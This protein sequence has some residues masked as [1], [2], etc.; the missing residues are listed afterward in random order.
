MSFGP[1][2][3]A[4]LAGVAAVGLLELWIRW[5]L[6]RVMAKARDRALH[7]ER[8]ASEPPAR[9]E[10][11]CRF[12]VRLSESEIACERPDGTV[13]RVGWGELQKV[14]VYTTSGGP[15]TTDFYWMLQGADGGGCL[16]PQGAT[17]EQDLIVRLQALPGFD[18][19]ALI[20][21]MSSTDDKKFLC[22]Q[23]AE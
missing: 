10:P 3:L 20:E 12:I 1:L 13:E 5:R 6:S 8:Y 22:W 21:A 17:G 18:N 23:R 16:V 15:F 7:P 4:I 14:E 2:L 19:E 11:E 9:L